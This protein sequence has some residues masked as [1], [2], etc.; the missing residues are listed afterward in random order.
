MFVVQLLISRSVVVPLLVKS[1]QQVVAW[2]RHFDLQIRMITCAVPFKLGIHSRSNEWMKATV[3]VF[4]DIR[5]R[6][7]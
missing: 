3:P 4:F 6:Y 1:V 7:D 5:Q 2:R